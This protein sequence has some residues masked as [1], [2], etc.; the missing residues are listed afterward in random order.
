[1]GETPRNH[2][3]TRAHRDPVPTLVP[4]YKV[5]GTVPEIL[6]RVLKKRCIHISAQRVSHSGTSARAPSV[7][8][9]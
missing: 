6:A 1:M 3:K 9:P 4:E 5:T 8:V 2:R 7:N